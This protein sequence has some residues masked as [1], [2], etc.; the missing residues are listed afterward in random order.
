MS[1]PIEQEQKLREDDFKW[2]VQ[3]LG[4]R[5]YKST[6]EQL[7]TA[8]I[9]NRLNGLG[10]KPQTIQM[11]G[12]IVACRGNGSK[13]F[14][15]HVDTVSLSPGAVDNAAGVVSL[16]ALARNTD[17]DNVCLGFP[18]AEELGL[19]GSKQLQAFIEKWHPSPNDLGLVV[20][21]DLVGHGEL[22]VTGI[23]RQ[24]SET[25]LLW[26][27]DLIQ[28]FGEYGYQV[29]SRNLPHMER[30]DHAPFSHNGILSLQLLGRNEDGI[31]P[32]YHQPEDI[33]IDWEA[34]DE[35]V[36]ALE[37]LAAS[38]SPPQ[39]A[40]GAALLLGTSVIPSV[41]VWFFIFAGVGAAVYE[42]SHFK[43]TLKALPQAFL[44]VV[45][46]YLSMLPLT[47]LS[48]FEPTLAEITAAKI[49]AIPACGWWSGAFW[50]SI[51][52]H[53]CLIIW[54]LRMRPKGSAAIFLGLLTALVAVFDPIVALPLALGAI[55]SL[56][57][58]YLA[59]LSGLYWLQPSILR[60]LAF[61]AVL[62]T[63]LWGGILILQL[64]FLLTRSK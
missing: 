56:F 49:Y 40:G 38:D 17:I 37:T 64:P 63:H 47:Q 59:L 13:L 45:I 26:L 8:E 14:M 23:G 12:N 2:L 6:N 46:G 30:S 20:S 15:A 27:N 32:N 42:Y 44:G 5:P 22:S 1:R 33:E 48:F 52:S 31:F 34:V 21:L 29:V 61:H 50:A 53:L 19:L 51:C 7:A 41:L 39:E 58:P 60:E 62:P 18:A 35:V 3:E 36:V 16:L 9:V 25:Q 11:H 43:A 54:R 55:G 10:W 57:S 24:W 4:P 28:P